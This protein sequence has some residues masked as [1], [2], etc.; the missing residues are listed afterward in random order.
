MQLRGQTN[1]RTVFFGFG[2]VVDNVK[3]GFHDRSLV[4]VAAFVAQDSRQ[5]VE[6][7]RL[8]GRELEAESSHGIDDDNLE[9]VRDLGHESA[10]LFHEPINAGFCPRLRKIIRDV[11]S[12]CLENV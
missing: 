12:V 9:L 3:N 7:E 6:H 8:L 2:N 5:E 11:I 1:Q 10:N 4:L